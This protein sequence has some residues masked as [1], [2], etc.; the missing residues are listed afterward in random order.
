MTKF[1]LR[2]NYKDM[3]VL[4]GRREERNEKNANGKWMI[5]SICIFSIYE[6]IFLTRSRKEEVW[7]TLNWSVEPLTHTE[8]VIVTSAKHMAKYFLGA[9][10]LPRCPSELWHI[11]RVESNVIQS[12][13]NVVFP[14]AVSRTGDP[15]IFVEDS[16]Y[17]AR[18]V[19]AESED[20]TAEDLSQ[21]P[22]ATANGTFH[23]DDFFEEGEGLLFVQPLL[24]QYQLT[25]RLSK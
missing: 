10:E 6:A 3:L 19:A 9:L 2:G 18:V 17:S 1:S 22:V 20:E 4:W 15:K 14:G 23:K 7:K 13:W 12:E 24:S 8:A 16:P 5:A 21:Y 11:P 25:K